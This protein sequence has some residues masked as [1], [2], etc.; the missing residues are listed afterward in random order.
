METEQL[1][2]LKRALLE[3]RELRA[4][5]EAEKRRRNEPIAILGIGCRYPGAAEGPEAFWE[6]LRRGGDAIGAVPASRWSQDVFADR[7]A[8]PFGGFVEPLDAFDAAFFG[9]SPRE[10][11]TMDPQQRLVLELAWEALE[12]AALPAGALMGSL[13]GVFI[14]I[15]TSDYCL[16][17]SKFAGLQPIDAYVTTGSVSHS[18]AAGRLAYWLGLQGPALAVDTAC[19]SSLVAVHLACQSLRN[20]ECNLALAGG[21]NA[22]LD[23]ENSISLS[24]AGLLARDG[25][26]KTFDAAAD[27]FIRAEGGGIVVL[28]RLSDAL[29]DNDPI[30]AIIK[31]SAVNQ[32][33]RS[34]GLTAPNG[35]A[36]KA[37]IA[38]ALVNAGVDAGR[39]G[40]IEAHGTGTALGDPIEVQAL[41]EIYGQGRPAADYPYLGSVKTNIGHAEA[42][43]GIAGLIKVVLALG[44]EAI[45]PHLHFK[46]P[47]PHIA[48]AKFPFKIP[49]DLTPWAGGG[50][51]RLGAV[52]SFGFSGT[53]AH[54]ILEEACAR[55]T[56]GQERDRPVHLLCISARSEKALA[57]TAARYAAHLNDHPQVALPDVCFT[58]NAR[59]SHFPYRLALTGDSAPA[60]CRQL[61]AY[62]TAQGDSH[63]QR[64]LAKE[65]P[66]RVAFLFTGQ[67]SQYTGM[68]R[69]LYETQPVFREALERCAAVLADK[70]PVPLLE[71]LYGQGADQALLDQTAYTQPA[72]FALEYGLAQLWGSW[73]IRPTLVMGHSVGE[74]VAACVAG[75]FS[76]EQGL[77]L[78]AERG[79][80]IQSLPSGGAMAAVFADAGRV[81]A[82][83]AE[84]G[85]V[86][87]VAAVN[88]ADNTVLSGPAAELSAVLDRLAA[89]GVGHRYLTVSHAFHSALME[90]V[91][92]RFEQAAGQV[93]YAAPQLD[94]VSNLTGQVAAAQQMQDAG[95]WREHMRS[96]VQFAPGMAAMWQQ[97]VRV[98]VEI[99]PHPVLLGMGR[100]CVPEDQGLWLPSLRR[101]RGQWQQML[102]SLGQL[103]LQ[104][105]LP[106]WAGFDAP[107]VRR[108]LALP[109]YPFE[110][111][112]HWFDN[113]DGP[114]AG[115]SA[116]LSWPEVV[117]AAVRQSGQVPMELDLHTYP[118]KWHILEAYTTAAITSLL[119]SLQVFAP[120]QEPLSADAILKRSGMMPLYR[121]L[122]LRWLNRL[123]AQNIIEAGEGGYL[124]DAPL[125]E[126]DMDA[127]EREVR[128]ALADIP[129]LYQYLSGCSR[130]LPEIMAGRRNPLDLLFPG[131]SSDLAEDL[132]RNWP[133]SRYFNAIATEV[134]RTIV[135]KL[136]GNAALRVLE[137]GAGTG[138]MTSALVPVLPIE[139]SLYYFTDVSEYFFKQST[140]SFG[141]YGFMRYGLLDIEKDPE[142]QGYGRRQY[143]VVVAANVLHATRNLRDTLANVSALLAPGGVLILLETTFHPP[144][145]DISFGLIEG[146]QRFEDPLRKEHPLLTAGAWVRLL[147]DTG[148]QEPCIF[149][150]DVDTAVEGRAYQQGVFFQN[151][152]LARSPAGGSLIAAD[153]AVPAGR[154]DAFPSA[155]Q[156]GRPQAPALEATASPWRH[157]LEQAPPQK[158]FDALVDLVRRQVGFVLQRDS[159]KPPGRRERLMDVGL[160]SLMAVELRDQIEKSLGLSKAL[161]ATLVFDYA[162]CDAVAGYLLTD[163]LQMACAQGAAAEGQTLRIEAEQPGPSAADEAL[164]RIKDLSDD[165]VERL[166]REK[167]SKL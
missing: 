8:S 129:F 86:V 99:G 67:G 137:I 130:A 115:K 61:Q 12:H 155:V 81:Q 28:K 90:P 87:A 114:A 72:L 123:A 119:A 157:L 29:S 113:E 3:I 106:D 128:E 15:G 19:S 35:P 10:A 135:E 127:L 101:G 117:A 27:G 112:R 102:E 100:R 36:Q 23:P 105:I 20:H 154:P 53:N 34:N 95:Y 38:A 97:G 79:R 134:L 132:Y 32:D 167:L 88:G 47:N 42:A 70:L 25:R 62:A 151:L 116:K 1:S 55:E 158:R 108:P 31:S 52:S 14:G 63:A 147:Q 54:V 124:I 45:P 144:W 17:R 165:E 9:I 26:C 85:R 80:L 65:P 5:L 51:K 71:V 162:T 41:G 139:R 56:P 141:D 73:G 37:V 44:H 93:A 107:Y 30:L 64:A 150:P 59:R 22:I 75:L 91:L 120:G 11:A 140:L 66:P 7:I 13:T 148:F 43:A 57:A 146:W 69:E 82:A 109:T 4:G 74:Y 103:Y 166:M 76:M 122:L 160:D 163:V 60:M 96:P 18:V 2:P 149:P 98:F 48:W 131:G 153:S 111:E 24:K 33:G 68:G 92:E 156:E 89:Q 159:H 138:G 142:D 145:F 161:P 77:R 164:E 58:A 83:L 78:V 110:R 40:Y 84:Q 118:R 125:P 94:V 16:Q 21:V 46:H 121:P 152:I 6:L 126:P 49:T 143:D 39:I 104:G 136:P 50:P 133:I